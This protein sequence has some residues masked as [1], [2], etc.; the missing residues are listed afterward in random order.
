MLVECDRSPTIGPE[1]GLGQDGMDAIGPSV[2]SVRF[3]IDV[4]FGAGEASCGRF[5]NETFTEERLVWS[6]GMRT[7][8]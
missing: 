6:D 1:G 5:K 7:Y 4:I 3:S 2:A 8:L